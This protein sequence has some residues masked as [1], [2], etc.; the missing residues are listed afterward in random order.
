MMGDKYLITSPMDCCYQYLCLD[1]TLV[2]LVK[3]LH[4]IFLRRKAGEQLPDLACFSKAH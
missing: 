3:L 1:V 2:S 4:V